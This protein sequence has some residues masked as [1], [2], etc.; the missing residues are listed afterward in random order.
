MKTQNKYVL[1]ANGGHGTYN[2]KGVF[3]R[4]N[5]NSVKGFYSEKVK[6]A[7]NLRKTIYFVFW[8]P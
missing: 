6:C 3:G 7:N 2:G 4:W 5:L 8:G 1:L